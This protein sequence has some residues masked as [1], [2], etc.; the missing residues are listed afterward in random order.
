MCRKGQSSSVHTI[1]WFDP[2]HKIKRLRSLVQQK[3]RL[4]SPLRRGH[5]HP[6]VPLVPLLRYF[7][8]PL[9]SPRKLPRTNA[10]QVKPRFYP[11][12]NNPSIYAS[13]RR[14]TDEARVK[15]L[16]QMLPATPAAGLILKPA[17]KVLFGQKRKSSTL[18]MPSTGTRYLLLPQK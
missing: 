5:E 13:V 15:S 14:L 17:R 8:P 6:V 4:N 9:P 16:G 10:K 3:Q 12:L 11:P 1:S 18:A 2:R 7:P